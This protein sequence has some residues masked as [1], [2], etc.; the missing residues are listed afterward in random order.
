[1]LT[2]ATKKTIKKGAALPPLPKGWGIYAD[3]EMKRLLLMAILLTA[4]EEPTPPESIRPVNVVTVKSPEETRMRTFSG[5]AK[6]SEESVLSFKVS[7]TIIDLPVD[8]G[9][10]IDRG[11][12]LAQLDPLDYQLAVEGA[13][14]ELARSQAR[15][16]NARANYDRVRKLYENRTA[17]KTDLDNARAEAEATLAQT[18]AKERDLAL[19]ERQLFYTTLEAAT[20]GSIA[21]K[22]AEV[23]E[24]VQP[25]QPILKMVAG[26]QPEV[27]I[28]MP[29]TMIG[30][31]TPGMLATAKFPA[32]GGQILQGQV[33]KIGVATSGT[34]T[35]FPVTL[36]IV[37]PT[38]TVR[39]G[40]T[41]EVIFMAPG[42]EAV[43][44]PSVA[45]GGDLD[46]TYVFLV[47][48]NLIVRRPVAVGEMIGDE[49]EVLE[50][51]NGGERVVV[52]G[53][54]SLTPGQ[55]VTIYKGK[56]FGESK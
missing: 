31:I 14:A 43:R 37:D 23:R 39:S 56:P 27:D 36:L 16:R 22:L 15:E 38:R 50:G 42:A 52:A 29:E 49:L 54:R 13:A 34:T 41:A 21:E 19:A 3:I 12:V 7:G 8:V 47:E 55:Q 24:N 4:C 40:M 46:G 30:Y 2:E 45:V 20:D 28:Q 26:T 6:A 1:M 18:V 11:Q 53:L 17:S 33:I 25:N 9:T 51:L 44:V 32:L 5:T 35:T 10:V 48:D